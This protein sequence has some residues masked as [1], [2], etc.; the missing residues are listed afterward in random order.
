MI[1]QNGIYGREAAKFANYQETHES[2]YTTPTTYNSN[3]GCAF[4][5]GWDVS[6]LFCFNLPHASISSIITRVV[7]WILGIFSFIGISGFAVSGIIY[8]TSAGD[9]D[10]TKLAKKAM[11]YSIIGVIVGLSGLVIITAVY[12]MLWGSN[13]F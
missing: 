9:E 4:S 10:R 12:W 1:T 7:L 2:T 13:T 5:G 11:F 8:L 6:K 3:S